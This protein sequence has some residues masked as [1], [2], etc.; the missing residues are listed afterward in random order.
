MRATRW[1]SL[2]GASGEAGEGLRRATVRS[3]A[4]AIAASVDEALGMVTLEGNQA[5]V[6]AMRSAMVS[7]IQTW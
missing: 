5:R 6:S 3:L 7:Q 2:V 4:A 1:L